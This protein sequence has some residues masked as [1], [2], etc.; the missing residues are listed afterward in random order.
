M[1]TLGLQSTKEQVTT[2]MPERLRELGG[3]LISGVQDISST[4]QNLADQAGIKTK[5]GGNNA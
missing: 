5:D 2:S 1:I 4:I 3:R